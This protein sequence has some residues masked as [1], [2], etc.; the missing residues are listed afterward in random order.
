MTPF[1]IFPNPASSLI[2]LR[3]NFSLPQTLSV[4]NSVGQLVYESPVIG[5][6]E[7]ID[8]R[9]YPNGIYL[10]KFELNQRIFSQAIIIDH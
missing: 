5:E 9:D 2:V 4:F 3:F 8:V 7:Q 6:A 10:I 1:S